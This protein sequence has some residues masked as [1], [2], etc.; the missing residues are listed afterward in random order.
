M[1]NFLRMGGVEMAIIGRECEEGVE[2]GK[3]KSFGSNRLCE[4]GMAELFESGRVV[5]LGNGDDLGSM[6]QKKKDGTSDGS[7]VCQA[8]PVNE[9]FT[10]W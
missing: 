5:S 3:E 7:V 6:C 2:K 4:L 9:Q 1:G 10:S 8:I